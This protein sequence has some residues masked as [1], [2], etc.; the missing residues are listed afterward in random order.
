MEQILTKVHHYDFF[1]VASAFQKSIRRGLEGDAMYW[2]VELYES[3]YSR[4]CWKRMI[5]IASEDVGLGDPD[6]IC[7]LMS[8][9][10]SYDY[11]SS[12]KEK[13]LPERLPFTHAVILLARAKKSRYVDHAITVYWGGHNE[14]IKQMPDYVF[15]KHTRKGK[16]MGRGLKFFYTDSC[17][18]CNANK[19]SGE[20][21]LEKMAWSIDNVNGIERKDED[22]PVTDSQPKAN[23]YPTLF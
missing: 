11:L 2:A 14:E 21:E 6:V 22:A 3:G 8:L 12:L 16:A 17:K 13:A 19:L 18:I 5:V 23:D 15:D 20:E 9:K 4:Y 1:E 7:Q 10:A